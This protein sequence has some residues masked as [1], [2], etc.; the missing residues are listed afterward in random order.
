MPGLNLTSRLDALCILA[1]RQSISTKKNWIT[2][3][4]IKYTCTICFGLLFPRFVGAQKRGKGKKSGPF[5]FLQISNFTARLSVVISDYA[6]APTLATFSVVRS[7]VRS[8][9]AAPGS[10][11]SKQ[12]LRGLFSCRLYFRLGSS[13]FLLRFGACKACRYR[14]ATVAKKHFLHSLLFPSRSNLL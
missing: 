6:C 2:I 9:T 13:S 8:F 10:S 11:S 7:F 3:I 1:G 5:Y 4:A 14:I 12:Q